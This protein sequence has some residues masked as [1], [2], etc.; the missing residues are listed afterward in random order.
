MKKNKKIILLLALFSLFTCLYFIQSTYAKYITSTSGN[1]E[2]KIARWNILV[3]NTDI[4]GNKTLTNDITPVYLQSEHIAE[5]VIAPTSS[6][7]FDLVIDYSNVDVSFSYNI[8]IK[9]NNVLNDFVPTAYQIDNG[10]KINLTNSTTITNDIL[11]SETTKTKRIRVYLEWVDDTRQTM[12]NAAD[13][14]VTNENDEVTL[15]VAITFTQ[16]AN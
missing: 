6:G 9:P 12:D 7:Y 11:Y 14:K 10:Q 5:N 4:T 1:V 16:K 15:Q 8:S 2:A 3:N 13:T